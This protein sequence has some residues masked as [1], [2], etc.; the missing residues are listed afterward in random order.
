[1]QHKWRLAAVLLLLC[2]L[3]V[4]AACS[5][6]P[7]DS[8]EP[9]N[10]GEAKLEFSFTTNSR[11]AVLTGVKADDKDAVTELTIPAEYEGQTV[12]S[13]ADQ[14]LQNFHNMVTLNLPDGL[15][16]IGMRS[17]E[18][19]YSLRELT[20][21]DSVES[22]GGT[23]FANC[24]G[25]I[26][27]T[28]G[29]GLTSIGEQAFSESNK[30]LEVY[31]RS[32]L[33]LTAGDRENGYVAY[34]AKNIY[35]DPAESNL[36]T[37]GDF[38]FY[39][40]GSER[41]LV[42]YAG[43]GAEVTLPDGGYAVYDGALRYNSAVTSVAI[44][45]GVTAIGDKAFADCAAL[46]TVKFGSGLQKIGADAFEDSPVSA[47]HI[48]DLA[49][50]CAAEKDGRIL[51]ANPEQP[52]YELYSNGNLV[53]D[54]AIPDGVTEIA[55]DSFSFISGIRTLTVP[56][57]VTTIGSGAFFECRGLYK[58]TLGKG[59]NK[60]GEYAFNNCL[61]L[62]EIENNSSLRLSAGTAL[63]EDTSNGS[64]TAY[65]HNVYTAASGAS[66]IETTA[67]G[68]VFYDSGTTTGTALDRK[69]LLAYT[70]TSATPA[71]PDDY[72]G[73]SYHIIACAFYYNDTVQSIAI[74]GGV[75]SIGDSAF[76][77]CSA[78]TSLTFELE[79]YALVSVGDFAFAGCTALQTLHLPGV[80]YGSNVFTDC[81][82]L[83]SIVLEK[84]DSVEYLG[85]QVFGFGSEATFA[86]YYNDTKEDA[87]PDVEEKVRAALSRI[88]FYYFSET[89]PVGE[90]NY[91]HFV[92][93]VPAA[94]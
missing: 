30:L 65:A 11:G 39:D 80:V 18:N 49:A 1:M 8:E 22:I 35:T 56:D 4:F 62:V 50:W 57:S 63:G 88:T 58:V 87:D 27:V 40:D 77:G 44:P 69:Y 60:I 66:K 25:L 3:F 75:W 2:S 21:P 26:C 29:Q 82:G 24:T 37:E 38:V 33:T 73:A 19:S 61:K 93:D 72:K 16:F 70:G 76:R 36:K 81:T 79:E 68:F 64:V 6:G 20:L 90:G 83:Q 5:G 48:D 12:Y 91:W 23:A 13:I 31:N 51:G 9:G 78:L 32:N 84:I 34:Y 92:N 55:D 46:K 59:V 47:A 86:F 17:F 94:W 15:Q 42:A 28:L 74:P 85:S 67:D 89:A 53:T 10:G 54:L 71:L 52:I 43:S 45:D 41:S 7:A 14:A